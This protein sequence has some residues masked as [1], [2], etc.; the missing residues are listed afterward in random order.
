MPMIA[1]PHPQQAAATA[2]RQQA[3]AVQ[4]ASRFALPYPSRSFFNSAIRVITCSDSR[5]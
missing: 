3:A 1:P 4:G 2:K 5:W